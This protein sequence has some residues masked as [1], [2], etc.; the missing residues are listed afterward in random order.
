M[1]IIIAII[2]LSVIILVHELGHF[3]VAKFFKVPVKEF[4]L[5]MGKR[6]VSKVIGNTRYSIKAL[7][8]GGSCAMIGEDPAG[9][10]DIIEEEGVIDKEKGTIN[11]DGVVYDIDYIKKNNFENIH[12]I[13]KLLICFA[14]PFFNFL[15]AFFL[16]SILV[17]MI[18][19]D[20][21]IIK[22][23]Q[24]F[25]AAQEAS[26]YSLLPNDKILSMQVPGESAKKINLQRDISLYMYIHND[27]II[28][29]N[30][31]ILLNIER[32]G[33]VLE[34][35]L[36]PKFDENYNKA[37]IGISLQGYVRCENLLDILD[38]GFKEFYFYIDSTI[39]SL[40]LLFTGKVPM[41]DI[42]GPVGT[43]AV[44]SSNIDAA[45]DIGLF[46]AIAVILSLTI[47]ISANLGIMNLLPIPA[48]DGGRIVITLVEILIGKKL[49]KKV[50]AFIY[51]GSMIL[52]L[53]F[54]A[55]IFAI[56]I[57]K[58]LPF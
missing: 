9:G 17:S 21:P 28:K 58:L 8:L 23:V 43:V 3:L 39:I 4:S 20:K 42:S 55:Y 25:T 37:M 40:K 34:T 22:E 24:N 56:D 5:G 44:M 7:P 33:E 51:V 53:G 36:I 26:P 38:Y 10:G 35:A 54:M 41:T 2:V 47:L 13:K 31:P 16:A 45:K 12:P 32:N 52:L 11:Y 19:I 18:G 57:F 46:S 50:E 1:S 27:D 48:L 30:I 29:N 49:N 6:L 15:L 14:G